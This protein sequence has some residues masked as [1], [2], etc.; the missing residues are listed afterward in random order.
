MSQTLSEARANFG[1]A[2]YKTFEGA[3][4]SFFQSE[5]PQLGGVR[6]RQ[7][8][9][10]AVAELVRAH[11]PETSHMGQG[12][13]RYTAV[14]RDETSSYGKTMAQSTLTPVVLDLLPNSEV[15]ARASGVKLKT[16][17]LECVARLF[18]QAYEQQGV[19]TNADVALLM[20]MSPGT[21]GKYRREYEKE[22]QGLLPTR[23]SV[24]DMGPTL[25]HKKIII[26]K[27]IFEGKNVQTV[28]RETDHSPEAVLRYISNFKQVLMCQSKA[29]DLAQTAYATKLSYG[30]IKQ[31]LALIE[32][33]QSRYANLP[34][35][36]VHEMESILRKLDQ[37]STQ[38]P[39]Q[40]PPIPKPSQPVPTAEPNLQPT[41]DPTQTTV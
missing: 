26:E 10:Q 38:K 24:H 32:E 13:I 22:H 17:K 6:S 36:K 23:G 28:C 15:Q 30:L 7:V 27:L 2:T 31:H 29:M 20:K 3:L 4:G 16:I 34:G 41:I 8:L 5:C 14:H 9:V 12:Q 21:V 11:F 19:L 35:G 40:S 33:Y 37:A 1:P 25:T 39:S 18:M